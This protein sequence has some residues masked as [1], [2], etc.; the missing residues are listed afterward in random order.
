M[1]TKKKNA[2]KR[3][4]LEEPSTVSEPEAPAKKPEKFIRLLK[5]ASQFQDPDTKD[6]YFIGRL[7]PVKE[8]SNWAR[9]QVTYG[10][11]EIIE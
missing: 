6:I 11:L 10:L 2:A 1:A 3:V 5:G 4:K 7:N 9:K 8:I